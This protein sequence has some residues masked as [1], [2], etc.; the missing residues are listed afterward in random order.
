[1]ADHIC[2]FWNELAHTIVGDMGGTEIKYDKCI[3][4]F[5]WNYM[6]LATE[7]QE[8]EIKSRT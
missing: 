3:Y 2:A 7:F 4:R 8:H 6:I 1:V 5:Q